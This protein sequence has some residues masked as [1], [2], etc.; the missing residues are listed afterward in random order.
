MEDDDINNLLVLTSLLSTQTES[1]TATKIYVHQSTEYLFFISAAKT[2]LYQTFPFPPRLSIDP[3][4][5]VKK[6][7]KWNK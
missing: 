6:E 4:Q 1:K 7:M 2:T 5:K 3:R